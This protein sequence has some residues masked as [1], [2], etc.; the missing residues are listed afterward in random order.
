MCANA[1]LEISLHVCVRKIAIIL[2][3]FHILNEFFS[4]LSPKFY[5]SLKS[6][7]YFMFFI[8]ISKHFNSFLVFSLCISQKVRLNLLLVARYFLLVARCSLLSARC[9]L[10]FCSLLITFWSL[11]FAR[12][13]LLFACLLVGRCSLLV[14]FCSLL[15]TFYSLLVVRYFLL[16]A[17]RSLLFARCLLLVTF[18]SFARCLLWNKITVNREK[19]VWLLRNWA[20]NIFLANFWDL[21]SFFW[22]VVFKAFSTCKTIFKVDIKSL[23]CLYYNIWTRF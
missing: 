7:Q 11:L 4:Y 21:R 15:L 18:C 17:R 9:S 14:T 23:W 20:T 6:R 1:D 3:K 16:V 5:L 2:W 22:M 19:M 8:F 12:C 10:I 13:S